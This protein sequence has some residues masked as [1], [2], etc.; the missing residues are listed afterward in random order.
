MGAMQHIKRALARIGHFVPHALVLV[1]IGLIWVKVK[2]FNRPSS[3]EIL[4]GGVSASA[5]PAVEAMAWTVL[6][7]LVAVPVALIVAILIFHGKYCQICARHQRVPRYS[8]ILMAIGRPWW[9]ARGAV[10]QGLVL[11]IGLLVI[12]FWF[13]WVMI[14]HYV[15]M[16]AYWLGFIGYLRLGAGRAIQGESAVR[17]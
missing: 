15:F 8:R 6:L 14:I 1:E 4:S 16:A 5:S 11:V 7:V 13:N 3:A 2:N 12:G 9:T 10:W 17:T